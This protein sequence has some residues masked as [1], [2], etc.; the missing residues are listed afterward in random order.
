MSR[1]NRMGRGNE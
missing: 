1:A